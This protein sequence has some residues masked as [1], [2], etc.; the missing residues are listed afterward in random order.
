VPRKIELGNMLIDLL[1]KRRLAS[2]RAPLVWAVGRLG[3]RVPLYGPLNTVV[4]ASH[5]ERWLDTLW[6]H[7]GD[8]SMGTIATM[9]LARRTDDRYR[10]V[11]PRYRTQAVTWLSDRDAAV[12]LIELVRDGGQLD[13]EEQR[14]V[15]GE[16]LPMGLRLE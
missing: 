14:E 16:S 3:Q 8:E 12:H 9:Q 2:V 5:V 1:P 10:D 6:K 15:F 4:P 13:S 7:V 11:S